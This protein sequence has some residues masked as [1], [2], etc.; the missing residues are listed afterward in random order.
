MK[1]YIFFSLLTMMIMLM[2]MLI[3]LM[4]KKTKMDREKASPFECGFSMMSSARMP[5]SIHF[6]LIAMIFLMFDIEITL[7]LP[8]SYLKKFMN[9]MEW[10]KTSM[11]IIM[12][13][14]YG[15]YHEWMNGML[16]WS[17]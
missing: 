10:L 13:V 7:M 5:F 14:L 15:L 6:F 16:E 11:L 8:I 9:K 17:K 4:S 2:S 3:F 12:M 1:I